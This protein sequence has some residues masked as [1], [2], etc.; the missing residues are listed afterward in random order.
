MVWVV[1]QLS[2]LA[3][4]VDAVEAGR[5]AVLPVAFDGPVLEVVAHEHIGHGVAVRLALHL[6]GTNRSAEPY[7]AQPYDT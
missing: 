2:G 7:G 1:V 3:S 4:V 6:R 5:G